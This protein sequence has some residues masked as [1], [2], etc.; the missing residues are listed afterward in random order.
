MG[1]AVLPRTRR[2]TT[3]KASIA[4]IDPLE[5]IGPFCTVSSLIGWPSPATW[6]QTVLALPEPDPSGSMGFV[7][8]RARTWVRCGIEPMARSDMPAAKRTGPAK[9]VRMNRTE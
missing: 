1:L 2:V 8:S 3:R 5:A 4:S 6:S 7:V 9:Q